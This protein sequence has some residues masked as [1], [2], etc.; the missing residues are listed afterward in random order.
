MKFKFLSKKNYRC[1]FASLCKRSPKYMRI[2]SDN[3]LS[4]KSE[5]FDGCQ[6]SIE[7][8]YT[9][10][11]QVSESGLSYSWIN[12]D[13]VDKNS[14]L[15]G[16]NDKELVISQELFVKYS[17]FNFWKV[18]CMIQALYD[19]EGEY[20][21]VNSTMILSLIKPPFNGS[22]T[23]EPNSGYALVTDFSIKCFDWIDVGGNVSNYLFFG[24]F[25]YFIKWAFTG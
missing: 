20:I 12:I 14:Y 17:E 3:Q 19:T 16:L 21:D 22:C 23:I 9:F 13:P 18:E 8:L 24:K 10:D 25:F 1:K 6:G 2:F 11:V 7:I 5:C 15:F 4:I